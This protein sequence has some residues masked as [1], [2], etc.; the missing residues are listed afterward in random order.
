M[1][2]IIF[3]DEGPC[4]LWSCYISHENPTNAHNYSVSLLHVTTL[5]SP[6]SVIF[7]WRNDN[8]LPVDGPMR[9]ETF[10]SDSGIP[11]VGGELGSNSPRPPLNY[12]MLTKLSRNSSSVENT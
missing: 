7:N 12:E 6:K 1:A 11:G 3:G 5:Y 4:E 10:R 9:T 8:Q 2:L